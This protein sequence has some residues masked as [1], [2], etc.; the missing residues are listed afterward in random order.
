MATTIPAKGDRVE[1]HE[2]TGYVLTQH[3]PYECRIA[4]EC[5]E[6]NGRSTAYPGAVER[7]IYWADNSIEAEVA[8]DDGRIRLLHLTPPSEFPTPVTFPEAV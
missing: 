6:C 4:C 5:G 3:R 2:L 8:C 1:V 7:V